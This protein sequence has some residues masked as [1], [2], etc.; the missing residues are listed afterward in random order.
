MRPIFT[1]NSVM[2]TANKLF[3]DFGDEMFVYSFH[4]LNRISILT[5]EERLMNDKVFLVFDTCNEVYVMGI[6]HPQF[7]EV[8]L[9]NVV[10]LFELDYNTVIDAMQSTG[11]HNFVLY[12]RTA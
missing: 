8:L 1:N 12:D 2:V 9:K 5:T 4:E 11:N 7:R 3:V 6:T 10:E